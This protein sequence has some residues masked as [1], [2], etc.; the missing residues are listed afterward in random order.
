MSVSKTQS[1]NTLKN[2]RCIIKDKLK[3]G[4]A[5]ADM[6]YDLIEDADATYCV[7][8][9]DN[10]KT[11]GFVGNKEVSYIWTWYLEVSYEDCDSR[12]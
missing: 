1:N 7:I 3:R 9:M 5:C 11:L 10:G 8:N 4:F 6:N 12:N 2:A